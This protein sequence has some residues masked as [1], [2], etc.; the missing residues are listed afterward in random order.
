MKLKIALIGVFIIIFSLISIVNSSTVIVQYPLGHINV[1]EIHTANVISGQDLHVN[2]AAELVVKKSYF[3]N[4][5]TYINIYFRPGSLLASNVRIDSS[6]ISACEGRID[7]I[8]KGYGSVSIYCDSKLNV[9]MN[10]TGGDSIDLEILTPHTSSEDKNIVLNISYILNDFVIDQGD[11]HVIE[12]SYPNMESMSERITSYVSLPKNTSILYRLPEDAKTI[13]D[14]KWVIELNGW[15]QKFIWYTDEEEIRERE[16]KLQE[17]YTDKGVWQGFWLSFIPA[18]II[19]VLILFFERLFFDWLPFG[20]RIH[21]WFINKF[22]RDI[23]IGNLGNK[24]Y[25][26]LSC[27]FIHNINKENKKKFK[28]KQVAEQEK[29][30]PCSVCYKD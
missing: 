4:N 17:E 30:K 2:L 8:G 28:N 11:Y 7:G 20:N 16:R 10:Y 27:P 15:D 23:V 3:S 5:Y 26:K 18:I 1:Q 13:W 9:T 19:S 12:I 14:G 21:I 22:R 29:Y 25:H 24:K 6:S